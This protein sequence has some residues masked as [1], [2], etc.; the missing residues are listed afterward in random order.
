MSS[1]QS[2][3]SDQIDEYYGNI[4]V[5]PQHRLK[6]WD[7][8]FRVF[9]LCLQ[10]DS[11][12]ARDLATLHLAFYLAS[13]GMYRGSSFL[14]W[15]DYEIHRPI[16]DLLL[17]HEYSD[18]RDFGPGRQDSTER[19]VELGEAIR[20]SYESS[21]PIVNGE[22]RKISP[23]DT[24][25]T[26]VLLGTYACTVASDRFVVL[27]LKSKDIKC[28]RFGRQFL[29]TLNGFYQDNEEQFVKSRKSLCDQTKVEYP[30]MKLLDMYFWNIGYRLLPDPSPDEAEVR[31]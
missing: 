28:H 4:L 10:S 12:P 25:I 2:D 24:L 26:K 16:I 6:S 11:P 29:E 21:I 19:V 3:V 23:S 1:R 20:K 8:C 18:L 17:R 9:G 15:K 7:H 30:A 5:D 14:I 31:R 22:K 13:W 27:G